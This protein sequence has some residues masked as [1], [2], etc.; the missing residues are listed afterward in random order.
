MIMRRTLPI[1][2]LFVLMTSAFN[3][4]AQQSFKPVVFEITPN[5]STYTVPN[6]SILKVESIGIIYP[7]STTISSGLQVKIN[8]QPITFLR[9][10][11]GVLKFPFWLPSGSDI[12][13]Y[14]NNISVQVYGLLF[15]K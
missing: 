8:N 5:S 15:P 6:D 7:T 2:A 14:G 10:G 11:V 9:G 12:G 13:P 1:I 3:I 4:S